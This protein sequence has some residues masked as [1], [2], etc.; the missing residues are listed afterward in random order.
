[1]A[2]IDPQDES[3][4]RWIVQRFRYDPDRRERRHVT[5]VAFDDRN[6]FEAYIDEAQRRLV[7]EKA[8]GLAES[9]ERYTGVFHESG[10]RKSMQLRRAKHR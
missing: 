9:A 3:L 1:M 4:D 5:E 6:E 10:H 7:R 2:Q 8:Q